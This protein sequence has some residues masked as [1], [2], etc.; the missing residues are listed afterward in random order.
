MA[1]CLNQI[2]EM[3]AKKSFV[4][5]NIKNKVSWQQADVAQFVLN[6]L[7]IQ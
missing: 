5:K 6:V 7:L 1:K 2:N 3:V 4:H